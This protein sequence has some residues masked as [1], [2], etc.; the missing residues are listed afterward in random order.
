MRRNPFGELNN[1]EQEAIATEL[2]R[3]GTLFGTPAEIV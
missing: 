1:D 2:E 3:Y